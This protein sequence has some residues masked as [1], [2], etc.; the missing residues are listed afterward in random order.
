VKQEALMEVPIKPV[1]PR[2][3]KISLQI[4]EQLFRL[5]S[6]GDWQPGQKLPGERELADSFRVSRTC[7][8]EALRTL[9]ALSLIEVRHGRGAINLAKPEQAGM[10][11]LLHG[12]TL[13]KREDVLLL[14]E[15]RHALEGHAAYLAAMSVGPEHLDRM[16]AVLRR[17][18]QEINSTNPSSE[19]LVNLD[20]EFHRLLI[21]GSGNTHLQRLAQQIAASL[22]VWQPRLSAIVS[23]A[24]VSYREHEA[25]VRALKMRSPTQA[26]KAVTHHFESTKATILAT[27]SVE[28]VTP[29]AH[30]NL[31]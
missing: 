7:V 4:A 16:Y 27:L 26:W 12:W 14:L 5:I 22:Y 10:F 9:E 24:R 18:R 6:N 11:Q 13:E 19:M 17:F 20:D 23:R 1:Q 30:T 29:L 8:R 3:S 15:I 28:H 31:R 21:E 25:I 2:A